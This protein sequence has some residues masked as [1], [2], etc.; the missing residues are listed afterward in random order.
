[1]LAE[2]RVALDFAFKAADMQTIELE[3]FVVGSGFE[4]GDSFFQRKQAQFMEWA[5][6]RVVAQW[7]AKDAAVHCYA[8]FF[9]SWRNMYHI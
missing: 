7:A 4:P 1:M 5:I 8:R 3:Y 2:P 9:G 6:V